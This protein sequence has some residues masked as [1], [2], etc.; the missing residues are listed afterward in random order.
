MHMAFVH[1]TSSST[2]EDY[3]NE[4][5]RYAYTTPKMF[6]DYVE[7]FKYLLQKMQFD[8][9]AKRNRLQAGLEKLKKTSEDVADLQ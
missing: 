6:M 9:S 4:E 8:V 3:Y 2:S 1:T 5:K 7:L